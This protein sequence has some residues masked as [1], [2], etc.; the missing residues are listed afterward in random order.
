MKRLIG[1]L[2]V[3]LITLFLST[4]LCGAA[5]VITG[6]LDIIPY[7]CSGPLAGSYF[8]MYSST[9]MNLAGFPGE[10]CSAGGGS[11]GTFPLNGRVSNG[12]G[13]ILDAYQYNANSAGFTGIVDSFPFF[14]Q[15]TYIS[16]EPP[17]GAPHLEFDPASCVSNDCSIASAS[18]GTTAWTVTYGTSQFN[19]GSPKL[20]G[21][22]PSLGSDG[23]VPVTGMYN[24]W[25]RPYNIAWRSLIV[26]GGFNGF[27]GHWS[28]QG[29]VL[30]T[31]TST[32][33]QTPS[34]F[35]GE[36]LIL[37]PNGTQRI[38]R[39]AAGHT[40]LSYD[41]ASGRYVESRIVSL[42]SRIANGYLIVVLSD[43][44]TIRVTEE[45]PFYDPVTDSY[46]AI[47][48]FHAGDVLALASADG[49][50][51]VGIISVTAVPEPVTVYNMQVDNENHNY[52]AAG[53]LVHNKTVT[54]T[55]TPTNTPTRTN[56]ATPTG[57]AGCSP[58][59]STGP[60]FS[61]CVV[62]T[63]QALPAD[64]NTAIYTIAMP[65]VNGFEGLVSLSLQPLQGFCSYT[66]VFSP[67]PVPV[68]TW[69]GVSEL[70]LTAYSAAHYCQF[71]VTGQ[72]GALVH[73][74]SAVLYLGSP[75][76][77]NTA[78]RSPTNTP[79]NTGTNT[80][81]PTFTPTPLSACELQWRVTSFTANGNKGKLSA[82]VVGNIVDPTNI[83]G[84]GTRISLCA[85]TSVSVVISDTSGTPTNTALT[86]G[87]A[88][89]SSG[90][91]VGSLQGRQKFQSV[92]NDGTDK[93]RMT[94]IASN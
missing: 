3:L 41:H 40:V 29:V 31:F 54:S 32:P 66:P 89:D 51:D 14:G 84:K 10:G 19:Q 60:D 18:S 37:V 33:T 1:G 76:A 63:Y 43:G 56:T 11:A 91:Q 73:A 46:K 44:S 45:H 62:P 30:P 71:Q 87:I 68:N 55:S 75:T 36:T 83:K 53:V 23:T 13:L 24:S 57:L 58:P 22:F 72:S 20:D 25:T 70:T 42:F 8:E 6:T 38:D 59:A 7:N 28:L 12:Q 80:N 79:T 2:S 5:I 93:L 50:S 52:V 27:T 67:N 90:C 39:L 9:G 34:C 85:G 77:T 74:A 69:G 92:S 26:G 4:G 88:C 81:T 65:S 48:H 15:G 64:Q 78:T 94:L 82:T 47:K 86:T 16:T 49:L 61:L 35:T 17:I 21:T